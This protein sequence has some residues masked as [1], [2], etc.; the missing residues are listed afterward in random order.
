MSRPLLVLLALPLLAGAGLPHARGVCTDSYTVLGGDTLYSIAR[1]CRSSVGAMARA[2]R[3]G[4]GRTIEVGQRL[5]VPGR[6]RSVR[7]FQ[8]E[9]RPAPVREGEVRA[10]AAREAPTR[11]PEPRDY[12]MERGD[13]LYSLARWAGVSLRALLAANPGIDP[14]KMEIGD[15]VILPDG[16]RDP[17][18]SRARERGAERAPRHRPPPRRQ[19]RPEEAAPPPPPSMPEADEYKPEENGDE[20]DV[21]GM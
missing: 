19:P 9:V 15:R 8:Q 6:S 2:N 13:T 3:L 11:A 1:L 17:A 5:L 20:S 12:R 16:A 4:S 7:T 18:R 21:P 10:R 14:H